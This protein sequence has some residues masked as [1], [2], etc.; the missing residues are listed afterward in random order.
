MRKREAKA[1][2]KDCESL[3]K[4]GKRGKKREPMDN[5]IKESAKKIREAQD[6]KKKLPLKEQIRMKNGLISQQL[7]R[8]KKRM[9][10]EI[11]DQ[12]Q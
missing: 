2:E 10:T 12:I 6:E 7:I 3:T 1:A 9:E 4:P 11:K 5:Y 8:V